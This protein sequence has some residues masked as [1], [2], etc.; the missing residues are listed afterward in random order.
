MCRSQWR[1][2]VHSSC[3]LNSS[4]GVDMQHDSM[5]GSPHDWSPLA[6]H[7]IALLG[8]ACRG[9]HHSSTCCQAN[10]SVLSCN[11]LLKGSV[12]IAHRAII[13]FVDGW[14]HVWACIRTF[15]NNNDI[16]FLCLS[17]STVLRKGGQ[18][19]GGDQST[20]W[21]TEGGEILIRLIS[22]QKDTFH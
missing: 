11:Y 22:Q 9:W 1:P 13:I 19:R 10:T 7:G 20:D 21:Q 6:I 12:F 16:I 14:K 3:S 17:L 2:A 18:V 5:P 8:Q 15:S 4:P